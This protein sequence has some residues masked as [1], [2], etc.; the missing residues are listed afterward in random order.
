MDDI[1]EHTQSQTSDSSDDDMPETNV[2]Y[3]DFPSP[4][5][6]GSNNKVLSTPAVRNLAK[7]Y[8]INIGD[9][10]GT[11]KDGRVLKDD[12]ISFAAKKGVIEVV[13][14]I[15]CDHSKQ[16]ARAADYHAPNVLEDQVIALRYALL[17]FVGVIWICSYPSFVK[18]KMAN[19]SLLVSLSR[20]DI[21]GRLD[22]L[23][24]FRC[25]RLKMLRQCYLNFQGIST[26][27]G[28]VNDISC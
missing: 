20:I 13:P 17:V 19:C 3:A 26:C 1:S 10:L 5:H 23:W 24:C 15:S 7:E 27:N 28:Q 16:Q 22:G 25:V 18:L 8:G 6:K 21:L 12:V 4:G 14:T 9:V 2:L 11:G